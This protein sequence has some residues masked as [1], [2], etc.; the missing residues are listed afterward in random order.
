MIPDLTA[1]LL[2]PFWL[3]IFGVHEIVPGDASTS[4]DW[5]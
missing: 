2:F 1:V 3:K 5:Y 4:P